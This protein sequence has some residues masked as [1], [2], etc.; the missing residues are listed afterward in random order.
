MRAGT[1]TPAFFVNRE[2]SLGSA[3][4]FEVLWKEAEN[5]INGFIGAMTPDPETRKDISQNVAATAFQKFDSFDESKAKFS[6][7]AVGIA[8]FEILRHKRSSSRSVV[9]FSEELVD[10]LT[11]VH[12]AEEESFNEQAEALK[13]CVK[14]L[15]KEKRQLLDM[16][17][18]RNMKTEEIA[19]E[20][21]ISPVN[22]RVKLMRVREELRK[23]SLQK[24]KNKEIL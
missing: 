17:Y 11:S 19:K 21:G 2:K 8:R 10:K 15:D 22:V 16:A 18:T 23:M 13:T 7:W 9:I 20:L 12:H 4:K 24:I 14:E 1:K 5:C 3:E 6:T